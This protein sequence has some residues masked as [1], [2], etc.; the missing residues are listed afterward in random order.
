MTI[1][2]RQHQRSKMRHLSVLQHRG[3]IVMLE[4]ETKPV[5]YGYLLKRC[6]SH[7]TIT[8]FFVP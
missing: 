3:G 8:S 1:P 5:L 4:I 6:I 7:I 2:S